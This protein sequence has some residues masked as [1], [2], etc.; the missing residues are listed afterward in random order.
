M[1]MTATEKVK[2]YLLSQDGDV[3]QFRN[4]RSIKNSSKSNETFLK[5]R[6]RRPQKQWHEVIVNFMTSFYYCVSVW[7]AIVW[8]TNKMDKPPH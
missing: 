2:K 4:Y 1:K 5:N 7:N 6:T 8:K 3:S